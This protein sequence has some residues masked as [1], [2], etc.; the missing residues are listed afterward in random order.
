MM[1]E[2]KRESEKEEMTD[3]GR[4]YIM[5]RDKITHTHTHIHN[6]AV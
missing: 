4:K 3:R 5:G 1:W 6:K 2:G